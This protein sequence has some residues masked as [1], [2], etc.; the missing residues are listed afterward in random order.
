M[1]SKEEGVTRATTMDC[2]DTELSCTASLH[3]TVRHDTTSASALLICTELKHK[4]PHLLLS[5]SSR[6]V[7][8]VEVI[9]YRNSSSH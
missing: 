2:C 5:V 1:I 6:A 8:Y 7:T 3:L 9:N 4:A